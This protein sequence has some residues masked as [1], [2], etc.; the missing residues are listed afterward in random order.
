MIKSLRANEFEE[1]VLKSEKVTVVDFWAP[2]CGYCVR[3]EPIFE[4][5]VAELGDRIEAYKVNTDEETTLAR[6]CSIEVLP[7]FAVFKGG[8]IVAR[9]IGGMKKEELKSII[10]SYL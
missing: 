5:I 8:V 4:E 6:E 7:T 1:K 10:E 9:P 2:W 3:M